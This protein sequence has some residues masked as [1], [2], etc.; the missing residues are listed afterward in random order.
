MNLFV[1]CFFFYLIG[2][3]AEEVLYACEEHEA[4]NLSSEV[5]MA[6]PAVHFFRC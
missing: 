6:N 4:N 3:A 2:V 1:Y 5:G